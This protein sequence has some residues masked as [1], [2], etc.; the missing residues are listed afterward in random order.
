MKRRP[1][2]WLEPSWTLYVAVVLEREFEQIEVLKDE[3]SQ[4]LAF[5]VIHSTRLGPA[6]GGIRRWAYPSS[7]DA[8]HDALDLARAMTLKCAL[9]DVPGGGGKTVILQRPG[10]DRTAAY[11]LVGRFVEMM[12]GRYFTGPDVGTDTSDLEVVAKNTDFVARPGEDGPGPLAEPTAVG[13]FAGIEATVRRLGFDGLEGVSVAVQGLGE[14]GYRLCELLRGSGARLVVADLRAERAERARDELGAEVKS[15]EEVLRTACDVFAPCALGGVIDES[16]AAALEARAVAGSA[17]NVLASPE[18]GAALFERGI[19]FAPDFVINAGALIH[20][21]LFQLDGCAPPPE[22]VRAIGDV[23]GEVLDRSRADDCPP[24]VLAE[25]IAL[26][27]V[28]Q[29]PSGPYIP[30]G[31][32]KS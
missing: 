20:G 9:A 3:A 25:R 10:L 29:A 14:V 22:R 21:A 23:I 32:T 18:S 27:R 19:L 5:V 1:Q 17:N 15:T 30:A 7:D 28:A 13:V 16:S 8:L 4:C 24:E 26:Q 2:R 11:S 12:G 31:R 6:F